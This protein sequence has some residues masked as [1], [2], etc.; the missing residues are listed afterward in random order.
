MLEACSRLVCPS[1]RQP[2]PDFTRQMFHQHVITSMVKTVLSHLQPENTVTKLVPIHH[3]AS[4]NQHE[5]LAFP[6][7]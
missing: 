5:I 2:L 4:L 3:C 6:I 1:M 7:K